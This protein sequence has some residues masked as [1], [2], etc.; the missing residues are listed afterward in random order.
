MPPDSTCIDTLR[1]AFTPPRYLGFLDKF[2]IFTYTPVFIPDSI[3]VIE[4]AC[5]DCNGDGNITFADALYVKNYYYQTPPGSPAPLGQ[6]DVNLDGFVNFADALYIKNYY[7]QTPPGSPPPCNLL[8]DST[9]M[10][11]R[12]Q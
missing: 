6:G 3:Y 2:G 4:H 10:K 8:L 9:L 11:E 7:Y 12:V 1:S 5:G